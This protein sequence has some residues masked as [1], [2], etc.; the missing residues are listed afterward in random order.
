MYDGVT[1]LYSRNGHNSVNQLYSI[2]FFNFKTY[3]ASLGHLKS[4]APMA[5]TDGSH[6]NYRSFSLSHGCSIAFTGYGKPGQ[7]KGVLR[8]RLEGSGKPLKG[9]VLVNALSAP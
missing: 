9:P 1:L 4:S 6:V 7:S 3:T 2:F 5:W 8:L